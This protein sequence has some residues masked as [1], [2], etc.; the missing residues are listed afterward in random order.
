M[1]YIVIGRIINPKEI[2]DLNTRT[3]EYESNGQRGFVAVTRLRT[4]RWGGHAGCTGGLSVAIGVLCYSWKLRQ[5]C[6]SHK[7]SPPLR[8]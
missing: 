2:H 5:K 1:Q 4:S 6:E 8:C 3:C 7:P